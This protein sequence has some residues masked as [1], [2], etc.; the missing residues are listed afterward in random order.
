MDELCKNC[1]FADENRYFLILSDE[2]VYVICT[3]HI[4]DYVSLYCNNC[5]IFHIEPTNEEYCARAKYIFMNW[6]D[7]PSDDSSMEAQDDGIPEM[8]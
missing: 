4:S 7:G 3:T 5:E 1:D 8:D 6:N 2:T